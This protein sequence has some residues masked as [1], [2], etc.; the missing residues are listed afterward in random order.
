MYNH[1]PDKVV[2]WHSRKTGVAC[3]AEILQAGTQLVK[4]LQLLMQQMSGNNKE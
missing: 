3:H 4:S 1:L 2:D